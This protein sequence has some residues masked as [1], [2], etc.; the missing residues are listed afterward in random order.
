V[1]DYRRDYKRLMI[2][3]QLAASMPIGANAGGS[4]T[5]YHI[6]YT[7]PGAR[8][9]TRYDPTEA[10]RTNRAGAVMLCGTLGGGKTLS[11]QLLAYLAALR[12]SIVVD[13]DPKKPVPDHSLERCSPSRSPAPGRSSNSCFRARMST[14]VLRGRP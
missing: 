12:G 14:R 11:V 9:P 7:I 5:G 13:V 10:S 4:D 2:A 1:R 8:R 6:G 3:E